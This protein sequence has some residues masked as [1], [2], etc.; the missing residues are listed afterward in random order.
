MSTA[1]FTKAT[2][3]SKLGLKEVYALDLILQAM[4]DGGL[5]NYEDIIDGDDDITLPNEIYNLVVDN[6]EKYARA[7]QEVA[8]LI[9]EAPKNVSE[10]DKALVNVPADDLEAAVELQTSISSKMFYAMREIQQYQG[11]ELASVMSAIKE[12]A[13]L[14][15]KARNEMQFL[16]NRVA[17]A[18]QELQELQKLSIGDQKENQDIIA[19][20]DVLMGRVT[21]LGSKSANFRQ[22][23]RATLT[24]K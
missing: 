6:F 2:A 9:G 13:Y 12:Q 16:G 5:G 21:A 10:A 17:E 11:L 15:E 4:Q 1:Q 19:D 23:V 18:E 22:Q 20:M 3:T 7:N 24:A 14:K 8:G